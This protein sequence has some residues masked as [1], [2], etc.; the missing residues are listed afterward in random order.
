MLDKK[1]HRQNMRKLRYQ[2]SSD[3]RSLREAHNFSIEELSFQA[4]IPIR[5]MQELE[6]GNLD[7]IDAIYSIAKFFNKKIRI[8]FY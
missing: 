4:H 2:L 5:I 3:I 7:R 8:E 6:L 1:K